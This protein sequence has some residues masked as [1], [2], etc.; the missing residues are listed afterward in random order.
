M[1][2]AH[3]IILIQKVNLSKANIFFKIEINHVI[4]KLPV[5]K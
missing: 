2:A 4:K 5:I 1:C 3:M